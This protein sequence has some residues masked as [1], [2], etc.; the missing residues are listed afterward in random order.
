MVPF[1]YGWFQWQ[2]SSKEQAILHQNYTD[3][4]LREAKEIKTQWNVIKYEAYFHSKVTFL[5]YKSV[6]IKKKSVWIEQPLSQGLA[7]LCYG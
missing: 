1:R 4:I 5:P 7:I 3:T 2:P 6:W